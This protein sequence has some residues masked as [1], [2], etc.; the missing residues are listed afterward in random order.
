MVSC[1]PLTSTMQECGKDLYGDFDNSNPGAVEEMKTSL[2]AI[3][4][5]KWHIGT[6]NAAQ[7]STSPATNQSL[8]PSQVPAVDS[9]N[10]RSTLRNNLSHAASE[11]R[12]QRSA[13]LQLNSLP[14]RFVAGQISSNTRRFFELCV[15]GGTYR[16]CL[17]EIC[18]SG[19]TSDGEFFKKI[20]TEYHQKLHWTEYCR[21]FHWIRAVFIRPIGVRY[22]RVSRPQYQSPGAHR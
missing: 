2:L 13:D 8:S 11:V 1:Y 6:P 5:P 14:P 21:K 9:E 15:R 18:I 3:Y 4:R 10:Q 19:V 22:V 12:R 17:R 16:R 7:P 20:K